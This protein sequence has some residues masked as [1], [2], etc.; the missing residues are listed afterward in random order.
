MNDDARKTYWQLKDENAELQKA[1]N[2]VFRA[3]TA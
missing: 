1:F 2:S 3:A